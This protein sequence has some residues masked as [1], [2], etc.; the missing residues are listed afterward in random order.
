MC[1]VA[2]AGKL[3]GKGYG[4]YR[5]LGLRPSPKVL[6][7][8]P[9]SPYARLP[10]RGTPGSAGMDLFATQKVNIAPQKHAVVS[11]GMRI[12]LPVD[13]QGV[14]FARSGLA[15]SHMMVCGGGVID[16]DYRGDVKV[17]AMNL[18]DKPLAVDVGYETCPVSADQCGRDSAGLGR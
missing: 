3:K 1:S 18:G 12:K 10:V 15:L 2:S 16:Q 11:L 17:I 8:F 5:G 6:E 14:I 9:T 4:S 7:C 13:K